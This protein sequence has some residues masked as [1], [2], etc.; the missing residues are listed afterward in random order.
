M[1]IED[2]TKNLLNYITLVISLIFVI[3]LTLKV[4]DFSDRFNTDINFG[5]FLDNGYI[6]TVRDIILVILVSYLFMFLTF[7]ISI[8]LFFK[9]YNLNAIIQSICSI[10]LMVVTFKLVNIPFLIIMVIFGVI[11]LFIILASAQNKG[12]K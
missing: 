9:T 4:S 11:A 8:W 2:K 12:Y 1:Y 6:S 7:G 10:I 3:Y 5:Y